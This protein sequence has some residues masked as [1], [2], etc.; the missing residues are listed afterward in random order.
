MAL[1]SFQV[2]PVRGADAPGCAELVTQL[3]YPTSLDQMQTRLRVLASH[4]AVGFVAEVPDRALLGLAGGSITAAWESDRPFG[5]LDVL[6]VHDA[7]RGTGVGS[8]LVAA[9]E[10]WARARGAGNL[11]LTSGKQRH[12]AHRF[13]AAR[14]Y[15][16]TG[17]RLIKRLMA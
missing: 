3:G 2:R 6:I 15:E 1:R 9:V 4:D 17:I 13:Y 5:R 10:E 12:E 11:V 7:A 8:A 16:A 14:G